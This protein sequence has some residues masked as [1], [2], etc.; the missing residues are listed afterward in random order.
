[1]VVMMQK[2]LSYSKPNLALKRS[3]PKTVNDDSIVEVHALYGEFDLLTGC[4][5]KILAL[6]R[7]LIQDFRRISGLEKP[8]L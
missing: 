3:I 7:R 1:M 5:L 6:F 8:K 2:H 4:M